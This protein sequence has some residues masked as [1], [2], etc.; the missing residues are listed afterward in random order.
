MIRSLRVRQ[1][2]DLDAYADGLLALAR[3]DSS[4]EAFAAAQNVAELF[5]L[6]RS[7]LT[8]KD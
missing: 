5:V 7:L 2:R 3:G 8:G 6:T 4:V 1:R